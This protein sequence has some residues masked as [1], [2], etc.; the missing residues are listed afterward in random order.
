MIDARIL[1]EALRDPATT[2]ALDTTGWP[3]LLAIARAEQ[4]IG[5][6]AHRLDGLPM[7]GV[8][9]RIL[10]DA[11]ASAEQGR[12]AAL[13]E[14]EMA[15]RALAPLAMPVILLKGTAYAAAGLAAGSGRSIGDLDILVPRARLDEAEAALLAAGWEWVKP[16]PYD[17]AYYRRWMHE[18]PPLIHR[19]RDRM[20]DVHHTILPRTARV[21]P[22]ADAL[23]A[24]SVALANG[25]RVL[26]P[27]DMLCHAAAHLMADG[28]LA[29]GM[30]NLWD[31][32]CLIAEFG[33]AGLEARAAVH[34]L[35]PAV[36]RAARQAHALYGTVIPGSW[37]VWD[38]HDPLYRR[39]ILARDGWGRPTR[40]WTRLGF[41]IR[42][43]AIR[44][45][46]MML[47]RH[48]FIKWRKEG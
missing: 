12:V 23:I 14:A 30:R 38:S 39:R 36:A 15:R 4:L 45:P 13:W 11:R 29:G 33:T 20:I 2:A 17:D 41:Y 42:S 27:D 43:H 19:E 3:A 47:A 32:H 40:K 24:D 26:S 21:T 10:A 7:P 6:L 8:A 35:G 48:L 18:L 22:D 37:R 9:A 46:P 5:T 25:L 31:I 28:D 44:M 16:D 1:A 34:G